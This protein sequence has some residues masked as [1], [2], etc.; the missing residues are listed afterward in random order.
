MDPNLQQYLRRRSKSHG[1]RGPGW[2][3]LEQSEPLRFVLQKHAARRLHYDL[4]MEVDGVL[5]SWA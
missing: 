4:R 3:G 1:S 2:T 5:T